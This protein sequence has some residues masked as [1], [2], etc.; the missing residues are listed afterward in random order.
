MEFDSARFRVLRQL[1]AG[2]FGVVFLVRDLHSGEDV[3]LKTLQVIRPEQTYRL[4]REFRSLADLS[5]RNLVSFY[6]LFAEGGRTYFT[7][8]YV[9]GHTFLQHVRPGLG[10]DEPRLLKGLAQLAT[11]LSVLAR[12]RQAASGRQALQR[13]RHA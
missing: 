2:G 9:P 3:A 1:G 8:E 5:H 6:E 7:M 12:E 4:K 10:V 13:A 11:G